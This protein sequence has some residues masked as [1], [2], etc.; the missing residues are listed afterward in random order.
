MMDEKAFTDSGVDMDKTVR[1]QAGV[2]V[3][4][5]AI[6]MVHNTETCK[7]EAGSHDSSKQV[8]DVG[9]E[10][11]AVTV[12]DVQEHANSYTKTSARVRNSSSCLPESGHMN[13]PTITRR[14]RSSTKRSRR[15]RS[16]VPGWTGSKALM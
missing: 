9:M 11:L 2:E 8:K 12:E 16:I 13:W 10:V 15:Q 7:Y 6:R 1:V 3:Y 4:A 5:V 14:R